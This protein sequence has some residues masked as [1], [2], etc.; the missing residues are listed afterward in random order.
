[1]KKTILSLIM[2]TS[3]GIFSTQ[4]QITLNSSDVYNL[5][6][7]IESA[8]DTMP[9]GIIMTP[10]ASTSQTWN[11][12][13]LTHNKLDTSFL[14]NHSSFPGAVNFPSSNLGMTDSSNDSSW[15]FLTKNA[16][17]LF[18]NGNH[19][20]QNGQGTSFIG[21]RTKI[22]FPSTYNTSYTGSLNIT[23]ATALLGIDPDGSG[24]H[25]RIDSLKFTRLISY[26]SVIDAW[27][28]MTTPLG[29]F[30][31]LRQ[32]ETTTNADTTWQL[33]NGNWEIQ[34]AAVSTLLGNNGIAADTNWTAT[35]WTNDP[36]TRYPIVK[37]EYKPDGTASNIRWLKATPTIVNINETENMNSKV[38][39]F[40]NPA[41]NKITIST[42]F[43]ENKSLQIFDVTGKLITF[44]RFN[45]ESITFSV[46]DY[47]KGI[48][49]YTINDVNGNV[50]H[51]NKFVVAK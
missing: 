6:D 43:S 4:A 40:P 33:V 15:L 27:G 39:L 5:G 28:N 11:F 22:T 23:L 17:G 29:T 19:D 47:E 16:T 34:S 7:M 3:V 25:G 42:T 2:L 35:W 18:V 48:Y 31:S 36:T 50:L 24:P 45:T 20:I 30:P 37:M 12:S 10:A 21:T 9:S 14:K 46:A 26:S 41:K 32:N 51:A 13:T 8:Y 38:S 44:E 1:M 49:F